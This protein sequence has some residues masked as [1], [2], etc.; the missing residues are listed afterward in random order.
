MFY[1][2]TKAVT[3]VS[4]IHRVKGAFRDA[5]YSPNIFPKILATTMFFS[6][7]GGYQTMDSIHLRRVEKQEQQYSFAWETYR[8]GNERHNEQ[9]ET[10]LRPTSL[11]KRRMTNSGSVIF[12]SR[13]TRRRIDES[14]DGL[15]IIQ[16]Q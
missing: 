5:I 9:Y 7:V 11:Q 10:A 14:R 12:I 1:S 4:S 6:C 16:E 13:E 15:S 3:A 8:S 2:I